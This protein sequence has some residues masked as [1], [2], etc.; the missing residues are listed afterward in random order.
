MLPFLF[1]MT[2][3]VCALVPMAKASSIDLMQQLPKEDKAQIRKLS[4]GV[5]IFIQEN[6]FPASGVALRVVMQSATHESAFFSLDTSIDNMKGIEEF[7][8]S[9]RENCKGSTR[10]EIA[11][12]EER[13]LICGFHSTMDSLLSRCAG[14]NLAVIAVGDFSANVME[15]MIE[16]CFGA[17][18]FQVEAT[19]VKMPIQIGLSSLPSGVALHVDYPIERST[20]N[21]YEDLKESW[22]HI[23]A[24]DLLQQRL[25]RLTRALRE[26]WVHPHPRFIFPVHGFALASEGT[27]SNVLS[28]L[29]WEIEQIKL[30][31]FNENEFLSVQDRMAYQLHHLARNSS[32]TES[33][34]IA[35]FYADGF[36]SG[37]EHLS[38]ES[39]VHASEELV[40][41]LTFAE[42]KPHVRKLL[43]DAN[44]FI[45]IRYPETHKSR[46][47]TTSEIE[48]M[49]EKISGLAEFEVDAY[50]EEDDIM[51][52]DTPS[53]K[54][55]SHRKGKMLREQ[56]ACILKI[57]HSDSQEPAAAEEVLQPEVAA[58]DVQPEVDLFQ[59][60]PI[61]HSERETISFIITNMA[62]KNIFELAFDKKKMEEKGKRINHVHPL[63]FIGHIFSRHDLK[64][65]MKR[66]KKSS[67]KWDAFMDGVARRMKEENSKNNLLMY[68]SGFAKSLGVNPDKVTYY[69]QKKDWEGLVRY[70]M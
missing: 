31:G 18:N 40:P 20:L 27:S 19:D 25:E 44:R 54:L 23:F 6:P 59:T 36:C 29:L 17:L 2:A 16:N 3:G 37:R 41:T 11:P 43:G 64:K 1:L 62:E 12:K 57:N 48:E 5:T 9:C 15:A 14:E 30:D 8:L 68:V 35:A 70:L 60:L 21:T 38:Y 51:L 4:N 34:K 39:F 65:N 66:I 52:L 28:F 13:R 32:S 56:G 26:N 46:Q 33:S 47:L 7:F 24:Q 22:M 10:P 49:V 50:Y 53:S 55:S 61:S 63:R 45:H 58:E 67:F 42:V 69:I